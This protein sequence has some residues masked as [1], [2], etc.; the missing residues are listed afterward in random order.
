MNNNRTEDRKENFRCVCT[1]SS[2]GDF[3][4][5]RSRP[6]GLRCVHR[7]WISGAIGRRPSVHQTETTPASDSQSAQSE[8]VSRAVRK[9]SLVRPIREIGLAGSRIG[10]H[11]RG[12]ADRALVND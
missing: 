7:R 9:K 6:R 5:G 2:S 11:N 10:G 4:V 12:V 1:S 3:V 8:E